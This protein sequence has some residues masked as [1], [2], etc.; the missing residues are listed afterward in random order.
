MLLLRSHRLAVLSRS[1]PASWLL[2]PV[3]SPSSCKWMCNKD[4]DVVV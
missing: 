4:S 2:V 3:L 1:V